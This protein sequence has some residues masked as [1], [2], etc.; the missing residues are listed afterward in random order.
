MYYRLR[1]LYIGLLATTLLSMTK[2]A[3]SNDLSMLEI[4][5]SFW[6]GEIK[7]SCR[8]SLIKYNKSPFTGESLYFADD[9]NW[10]LS[11]VSEFNDLGLIVHGYDEFDFSYVA[12]TDDVQFDHHIKGIDDRYLTDVEMAE[13]LKPSTRLSGLYKIQLNYV[14][15]TFEITNAE[16]ITSVGEIDRESFINTQKWISYER[17]ISNKYREEELER[18]YSYAVDR[19]YYISVEELKNLNARG[20]VN[21]IDY[22][23]EKK[24]LGLVKKEYSE[25]KERIA[26]LKRVNDYKFE[27]N[28][29]EA[30]RLYLKYMD[31]AYAFTVAPGSINIHGACEPL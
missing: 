21:V 19:L 24:E 15:N 17:D 9:Q 3:H 10:I 7:L 26:E 29:R 4:K 5:N 1:L 28:I 27:D 20:A 25:Y 14:D 12:N 16:K 2:F 13:I 11:N 8:G 22:T 18:K 23:E 6:G 30:Q 31:E